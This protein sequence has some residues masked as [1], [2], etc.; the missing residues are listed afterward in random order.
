MNL[1]SRDLLVLLAL[2]GAGPANAAPDKME[3]ARLVPA[4]ALARYARGATLTG[5]GGS[6]RTLLCSAVVGDRT[7]AKVAFLCRPGDTLTKLTDK[8]RKK[9]HPAVAGL[10]R[11]A[12]GDARRVTF[13]DDDT[14]CEVEVADQVGSNALALAKAVS[15]ALQ[16]DGL[17]PLPKPRFTLACE[18]L[19]PEPLRS[20]WGQGSTVQATHSQA[21]QVNCELAMAGKMPLT[22]SYTCRGGPFDAQYWSDYRRKLPKNGGA[23]VVRVGTGGVYWHASAAHTV[24]F[25]DRE[26]GCLVSM[27]TFA[28]DKRR[29]IA[30][31]AQVEKALTLEAVR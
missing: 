18:R 3:C 28:G 1:A 13:W 16:P 11:A 20:R 6:D 24:S 29:A 22:V 7:A 26:T 19:L 14:E 21:E 30:L 9:N 10:G 15:A 2:L 25:A 23:E 4:A 31:A 17:P 12:F 5:S 27:T 8:M